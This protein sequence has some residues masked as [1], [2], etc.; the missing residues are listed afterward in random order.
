[1]VK[2]YIVANIVSY[3]ALLAHLNIKHC[4]LITSYDVITSHFLHDNATLRSKE[5]NIY[6]N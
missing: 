5:K 3:H 2:I 4:L 1:M 6:F